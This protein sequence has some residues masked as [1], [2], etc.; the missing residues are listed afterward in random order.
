MIIDIISILHNKHPN[1]Q[2]VAMKE[3]YEKIKAI[4]ENYNGI[5]PLIA[6][7]HCW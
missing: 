6:T 2:I 4:V 5:T 7:D 1:K 3:S